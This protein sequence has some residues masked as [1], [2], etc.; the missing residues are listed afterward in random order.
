MDPIGNSVQRL[1]ITDQ[2][3]EVSA[4]DVRK[5]VKSIN[6][7]YRTRH[8]HSLRLVQRFCEL[9]KVFDSNLAVERERLVQQSSNHIQASWKRT[10][11]GKQE[12][13]EDPCDSFTLSNSF[14]VLL[15]RD[16]LCLIRDARRALGSTVGQ[17]SH[18]RSTHRRDRTDTD[19]KPVRKVPNFVR[20]RTELNRHRPSLLEPILP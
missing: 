14:A 10:K 16:S 19:C 2:C 11:L 13:A 8:Q 20:Q 7:G 5:V 15:L 4:K 18:D 17:E 3:R 9:R 12:P 1:A 6:H